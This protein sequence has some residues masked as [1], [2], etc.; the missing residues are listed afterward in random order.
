MYLPDTEEQSIVTRNGGT[1]NVKELERLAVQKFR[2][3]PR[4]ITTTHHVLKDDDSEFYCIP[5]PSERESRSGEPLDDSKKIFFTVPQ[6]VLILLEDGE[7]GKF[8]CTQVLAQQGEGHYWLIAN[9]TS[10]KGFILNFED[11][12]PQS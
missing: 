3:T 7:Y 9:C 8:T 1:V 12:T 10:R 6:Q 4:F 11:F 5:Q 2:E